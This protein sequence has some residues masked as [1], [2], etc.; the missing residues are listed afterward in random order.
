MPADGFHPHFLVKDNAAWAVNEE[1]ARPNVLFIQCDQ[2]RYDCQGITKKLVLTPNLDE[3]VKV[4]TFFA[5]AFTPI[6]ICCTTR[7]IY[8]GGLWPEQY[9]GL[10]NYEITLPVATFDAHIWTKDIKKSGYQLVNRCKWQVHMTKKP[11][12][13]GFD[14]YIAENDYARYRKYTDIARALPT[15]QGS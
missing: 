6:P 14:N 8:L 4:G 13:F 5:N 1:P 12:D 2:F 10:W 9:K 11:K 3:L 15:I 7:Q